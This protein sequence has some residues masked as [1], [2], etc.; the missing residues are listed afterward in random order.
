M[1]PT[2][3]GVPAPPLPPGHP[4]MMNMNMNMGMAYG[5]P[6][7]YPAPAVAGYP[8]YAN[9]ASA[10]M[11][12]GMPHPQSFGAHVPY[13]GAMQVAMPVVNPAEA[14]AQSILAAAQSGQ[15]SAQIEE[16]GDIVGPDG[17]RSDKRMEM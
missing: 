4:G 3:S 6:Y 16:E 8:P 12:F 5:A 13:Q 10:S 2:N 14:A 11:P 15:A 17:K 7:G 9:G 1:W